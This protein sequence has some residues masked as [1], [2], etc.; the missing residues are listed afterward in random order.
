MIFAAD[1]DRTLLFSQRM[2]AE[3]PETIPVEYRQGEP[4]G[5]MTEHA[6]SVLYALSKKMVFFVNTLRGEEQ[7]KRICFVR[8]GACEYL[9]CQNGLYL[10]HHG[11][12]DTGWSRFVAGTVKDLPVSLAAGV[13]KVLKALP[14]IECLSKCYEY[15]AVFFVDEL[16]FDETCYSQLASALSKDGWELYRQRKKLYLSPIAVGKGAV[17]RRVQELCGGMETVSFGDSYFDVPMLKASFSAFSL[18]GCE[19]YGQDWG[20]PINYSKQPAQA[21]TE[22]ILCFIR[23]FYTQEKN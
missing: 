13:D 12:L 8:D 17:L 7:A 3:N 10:Y 20:F 18:F 22:E 23:D 11:V 2:L 9:A 5:F 14:G 19:L 1:L 4:F 21:G 16:G 15:L 6:L